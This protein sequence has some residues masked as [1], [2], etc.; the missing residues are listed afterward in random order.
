M[1]NFEFKHDAENLHDALGISEEMSG[2]IIDSAIRQIVEHDAITSKVIESVIKDINPQSL[3]EAI[4]I[5]FQ[6]KT[7]SIKWNQTPCLL[8]LQYSN[9]T[10]LSSRNPYNFPYLYLTITHTK[11]KKSC[12]TN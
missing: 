5:G 11:S 9:I 10:I 3:L 1:E 6:L 2:K 7:L 12:L 8:L 4:Y